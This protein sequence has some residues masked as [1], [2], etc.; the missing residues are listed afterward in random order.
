[1][2]K[3]EIDKS[4]SDLS[5]AYARL[6]LAGYD[7]NDIAHLDPTSWEFQ[8]AQ[9]KAVENARVAVEELINANEE[10][11]SPWYKNIRSTI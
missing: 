7:E 6:K 11:V 5:T 4:Y 8:E 1:M 10:E 2:S 3:V 9:R